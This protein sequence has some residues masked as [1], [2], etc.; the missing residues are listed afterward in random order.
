MIFRFETKI[1]EN[2]ENQLLLLLTTTTLRFPS[3]PAPKTTKGT[4]QQK[5]GR[6][7]SDWNSIARHPQ[8]ASRV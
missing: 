6:N 8:L 3:S 2:S 4:E 1:N 5:T 7:S